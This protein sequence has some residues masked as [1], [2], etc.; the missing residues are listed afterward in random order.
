MT[1]AVAGLG[2]DAASP[3]KRENSMT[4]HPSRAE[5]GRSKGYPLTLTTEP[6]E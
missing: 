2:S 1:H 4:N 6:E 3:L 5:A